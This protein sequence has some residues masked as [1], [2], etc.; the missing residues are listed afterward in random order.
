MNIIEGRLSIINE[1]TISYSEVCNHRTYRRNGGI[2]RYKII[3]LIHM[4]VELNVRPSTNFDIKLVHAIEKVQAQMKDLHLVHYNK[5]VR[6]W[7]H[8][9]VMNY[10]AWIIFVEGLRYKEKR[11]TLF[12]MI[13]AI[14]YYRKLVK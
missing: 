10:C 13:K 12:N 4:L 1:F 6:E 9:K 11:S 14:L 8:E 3:E 2:Y 7:P 5:V